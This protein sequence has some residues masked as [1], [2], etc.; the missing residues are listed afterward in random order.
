MKNRMRNIELKNK[1]MKDRQKK[2]QALSD[3]ELIT[4]AHRYF[5]DNKTMPGEKQLKDVVKVQKT[6]MDD[7]N[8]SDWEWNQNVPEKY[9]MDRHEF[10]NSMG[11]IAIKSFELHED[12]YPE[13]MNNEDLYFGMVLRKFMARGNA[14]DPRRHFNG[15][16][17]KKKRRTE[18]ESYPAFRFFIDGMQFDAWLPKGFHANHPNISDMNGTLCTAEYGSI[19]MEV[20]VDLM[21][22]DDFLSEAEAFSAAVAGL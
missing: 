12:S 1:M 7:M 21:Q 10:V 22:E 16:F 8:A 18:H 11:S 2:L 15:A 4:A 20:V 19:N 14:K 6:A 3:V 13:N 5:K 9:Q 17:V